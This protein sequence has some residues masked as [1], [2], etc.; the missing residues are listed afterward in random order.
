[1]K[2]LIELLLIL[3]IN[4]GLSTNS[5]AK[6]LW[7]SQLHL[8]LGSLDLVLE[9]AIKDSTFTAF[10]NPKGVVQT[11]GFWR[12]NLARMTMKKF[13]A[14]S[15]VRVFKGKV[16]KRVQDT[17]WLKGV[18]ATPFGNYH[19][20]GYCTNSN[21]H[22]DLSDGNDEPKG[23]LIGQLRKE[24]S[25]KVKDYAEV[26]KELLKLTEQ[27][28]YNPQLLNQVQWK[29]FKKKIQVAAKQAK[30]DVELLV[31]FYVLAKQL[32]FSHYAMMKKNKLEPEVKPTTPQQYVEQ[33]ELA[34]S[35]AYLKIKSFRGEANEIIQHF[36]TLLQKNYAHLIID[37][38]DNS[39][40]S[41]EA[42][43]QLVRYLVDTSYYGGIFLTQKWFNKGKAIP[44]VEDY[45]RLAH[46]SETSFELI[47]K[48]I[49]E[50][51][52][53]CLRIDPAPKQYKGS[54]YVLTKKNTASTCEPI[55]YC[56]K[57]YGLATTV[58]ETTAGAMLN[59]EVF[60]LIDG[61]KLFMPTADY[62]AADGYRIDKKGV[63]PNYKV[64]AEKALE[65]TL[66]LIGQ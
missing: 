45:P 35:I 18:L 13:K 11:L 56:L 15:F 33:K 26:I 53:L 17:T 64:K 23:V 22:W 19:L 27:R 42:G 21:V 58:G 1:M 52:G 61:F 55:V 6:D 63:K 44:K 20:K 62:Y 4:L 31:K 29:K 60:E 49:H 66:R 16:D 59:G 14:G 8:G 28:L 43:M 36:D 41:I 50:Q 65:Y 32:P 47:I 24:K 37:L 48:G 38:R 39:G 46:F 34:D 12:G 7:A 40:G 25:S 30:D 9:L 10:S 5:I 3:C 2:K 54:L 57:Q 51:E